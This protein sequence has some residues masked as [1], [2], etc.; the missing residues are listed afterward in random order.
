MKISNSNPFAPEHLPFP[1]FVHVMF[2]NK[3]V[4]IFALLLFIVSAWNSG[5]VFVAS[6][7]VIFGLPAINQNQSWDK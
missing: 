7:T 5:K 6:F 2:S 1:S 4:V 3:P